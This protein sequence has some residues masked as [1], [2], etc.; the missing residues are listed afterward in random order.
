MRI[1]LTDPR[2]S[3]R[4]RRFL[5]DVAEKLKQ[6]P[7]QPLP[8]GYRRQST[9][10]SATAARGNR[11][12]AGQAYLI[13]LIGGRRPAA[14]EHLNLFQRHLSILVSVDCLENS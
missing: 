7:R 13:S 1:S 14:E 3:H 8:E 2:L 12:M 9:R 10:R 4:E 11:Q 6:S 5:R